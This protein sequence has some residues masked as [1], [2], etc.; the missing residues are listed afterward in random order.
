[1]IMYPDHNYVSCSNKNTV[2]I[3]S[4]RE[5]YTMK[6]SKVLKLGVVGL[7][8]AYTFFCHS[9]GLQLILCR[10]PRFEYF[11]NANAPLTF[12]HASRYRSLLLLR[13]DTIEFRHLICKR[14]LNQSSLTLLN[15]AGSKEIEIITFNHFLSVR[16]KD[17]IDPALSLVYS[18]LSLFIPSLFSPIS[19]YLF[20]DPN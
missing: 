1:M 20:V 2:Y 13:S 16:Q 14:L 8:N 17:K 18:L 12:P 3:L 15:P 10:L 19:F 6:S 5:K 9:H 4:I 11:L 7:C